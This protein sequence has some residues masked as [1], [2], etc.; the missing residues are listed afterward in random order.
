MLSDVI[1]EDLEFASNS[2]DS[3]DSL[4]G[5]KV[6]ITGGYGMIGTY[7]TYLLLYLN[8]YHNYNI[9]VVLLV[10]CEKKAQEKLNDFS[11]KDVLFIESDLKQSPEIPGELDY[12]IH[13]ASYASP[14]YFDEDPIGVLEPNLIGTYHL[15]EIAKKKEVRSFLFFSSGAVYG[16]SYVEDVNEKDYGYVDILNTTSCYSESKRMAENMCACWF[17]QKGV[18]VKI[19]RPAHIYGPTMKI[20]EDTRVVS[21]F[22][23]KVLNYKNIVLNSSGETRR[24]F[25]YLADALVGFYTVMLRGANGQ[26]YNIGNDAEYMS[27]KELAD[28]VISC[29][30]EKNLKVKVNKESKSVNKMFMISNK[31]YG[32]GWSCKFSLSNG[33]VRTVKHFNK[34]KEGML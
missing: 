28:V 34:L 30:P 20:G 22:V 15:L 12:I 26:A 21:D 13:A 9:K 14:R 27:V 1:R 8:E 16:N 23:E 11:C 19:V 6:L 29:F 7:M 32:L 5:S 33:I 4:R 2:I 31:S 3:I 10:R 25:C 18:P 17:K 24:S